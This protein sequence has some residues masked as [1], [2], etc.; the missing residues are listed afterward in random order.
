MAKKGALKNV[1]KE[2]L[3][4]LYWGQRM[5]RQEVANMLDVTSSAIEYQ[6]HRHGIPTRPQNKAASEANIGKPTWNK[7]LTKENNPIL[8]AISE[9]LKGEASPNFGKFGVEHPTFHLYHTTEWKKQQS[10]RAKRFRHT[11]ASKAILREKHRALWQNSD[12]KDRLVKILRVAQAQRPTKGEQVLIDLFD[13][14]N[15]PYKYVGDGALII[16]GLNPDFI[17]YNGQKKIIE[18]FGHYW[19]QDREDTPYERTEVG[20][21]EVF[22]RLGYETLIIWDYELQ[23]KTK[24]L[25]KLRAFDRKRR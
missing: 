13:R 14:H 24:V 16:Y 6:L 20:R 21:K 17:N 4:E 10:I 18:F 9:H 12:Y 11:D 22:S 3:E 8:K 1:T 5:S 25:Q 7:G 2:M 23:D 15:L 19:H